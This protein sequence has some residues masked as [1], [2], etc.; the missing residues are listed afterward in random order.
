MIFG[1][2]LLNDA[3]AIVL[4]HTAEKYKP[5]GAEANNPNGNL[6]PIKLLESFGVFLLVFF[7]SL[8]VGVLV[9]IGTSLFL[10]FTYIRRFP[11]IES[12]IVLLIAYASYFFANSIELS[13]MYLIQ[14]FPPAF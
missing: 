8:L 5:R 2:S 14:K 11:K 1:E 10:K 13:G 9:G 4:F 3:I 6:T 7:G 12:C